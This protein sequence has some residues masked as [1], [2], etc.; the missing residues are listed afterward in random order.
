MTPISNVI[1]GPEDSLRSRVIKAVL[2]IGRPSLIRKA[3]STYD[4]DELINLALSLPDF[5]DIY[6]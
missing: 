2:E 5:S 4:L 1:Q 3:E 6:Y